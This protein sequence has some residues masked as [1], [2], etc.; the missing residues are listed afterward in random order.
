MS[1][2]SP[3]PFGDPPPGIDLSESHTARN[4]AVTIALTVLATVA[5]ILRMTTRARI[6]KIRFEMDDW[7]IVASLVP[8]YAILACTIVGGKY[9]LG[10][11]VWVV[12]MDHITRV[13]QTHFAYVLIYVWA[14]PLIK[15][16]I[17]TFYR[18]IF[19]MTRI[20]WLCAFLTMGYFIACT[21]AFSSCCQP[22][23]YYWTQY[24]HPEGGYC[25]FDLYPFY[26]GNASA[27]VATDLL[28]L[29]VPIPLVW[30]L[31]M[32]R[33][34]KGL[35]TGIF[36][37]GGFVCV[38]SLIR[39][40]SM[41]PL[42]H[43]LDVT[44]IMGDVYVWSSV[45][46]CIGILCAC[47]PT[48]QPLIRRTLKKV[49]GSSLAR[50]RL[51]ESSQLGESESRQRGRERPRRGRGLGFGR[52]GDGGIG[53]GETTNLG[54]PGALDLRPDGD[55]ALLTTTTA[56]AH[57]EMDDLR[58]QTRETSHRDSTE[59]PKNERDSKGMAI[60]IKSD[61]QWKEEHK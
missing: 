59:G 30:G 28:I 21:I 31:Q 17:I 36:L 54:Y 12:S 42:K 10:K 50:G 47:L 5:V 6:Q 8:T 45:E 48:L 61:F 49:L 16:S 32:R 15:L 33:V 14:I 7:F 37:L 51:G 24:S 25:R 55:E 56:A 34:T 57:V 46:P 40:Y 53:N 23:S 41:V 58:T 43:N 38:A 20:M 11:H 1:S 35:I 52:L 22:P 2:S 13:N 19:G 9:G 60:H 3:S 44:W 29:V 39:I 27:N 26:L 18:R 4:N